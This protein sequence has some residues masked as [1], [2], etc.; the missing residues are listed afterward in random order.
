MGAPSIPTDILSNAWRYRSFRNRSDHV[1]DINDL[2]S[3]EAELEISVSAEGNRRISALRLAWAP[4]N[5][6]QSD[7]GG[8]HDS[9]RI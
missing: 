5:W 4:E 2:R 8:A 7:I 9:S 6:G 3:G 1:D